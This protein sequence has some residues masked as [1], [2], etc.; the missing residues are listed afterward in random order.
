MLKAENTREPSTK[1]LA[2]FG[3]DKFL[4]HRQVV[5]QEQ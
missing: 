3:A 1:K 5:W 2:A 4:R